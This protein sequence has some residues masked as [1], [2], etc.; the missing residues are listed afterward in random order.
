[1]DS[2]LIQGSHAWKE[3]RK[4][5]ISATDSSCILGINPWRTQYAL[6][7][8]KMD[9]DPPEV[10]NEA[11]RRGSMMEPY[12]REW[13][14]NE[15]GIQC[16]PVVVFKDF[17]MASLDGLSNDKQTLIEIKCGSRSFA[18]AE[19]GEVA[20]YYNCQM[21]H[22]MYVSNVQLAY[23]V[24]FNGQDGIILEVHRDDEFID[25]MIPKLREFYECLI[26]FTPPMMTMRDYQ[27]KCGELWNASAEN[28]RKAYQDRKRAEQLEELYR[29]ELIALSGGSSSMGAGIK[30]SKIPRRGTIE[31]MKIPELHGLD[32][33]P[34]RK[35]G[36][37]YWR[38]SVDE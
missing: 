28:Y 38:I 13:F 11:M 15:T 37:E 17:M 9:L 8:Q 10:E 16:E 31:F 4:T 30:L 18:Q 7:R 29:Q 22:Q 2:Y 3:I 35:K 36:S 6:W 19:A 14:I 21:Q 34:Y 5:K 12:A 25:N 33:E 26:S 23:Y 1:M 32:L 24:A 20:S 27:I